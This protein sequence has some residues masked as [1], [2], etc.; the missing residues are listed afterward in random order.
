MTAHAAALRELELLLR[1]AGAGVFVVSTGQAEQRAVQRAIYGATTDAEVEERLRARLAGLSSARVVM[2]GVPSDVGAGYVR[3]AN[4]GPQAIRARMAEDDPNYASWLEARGV[5][6][7]GDVLVVPQL[8]SDEMLSEAQ[9]ERTRRAC[10]PDVP[11]ELR[12]TLP[13]SPLSKAERVLDLALSIAPNAAPV[14]LGGD[15]SCAWPAV[16]ALA[17]ARREPWGVVQID[18]HT[19]LLAERL[20]VRTCFA[21]WSYHANEL[22]GR[23]GKLVQVGIRATRHDRAHWEGTLGVRQFWADECLRDPAAALDAIA[24]HVKATGVRGV[25]FSNDIDGT[26]ERFADATGTPEPNGLEPDFVVALMRRLG[27]EVGL[28]GGDVMEVAP[29]VARTPDGARRTVGLAARYLRETLE[30]LTTR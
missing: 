11:D 4:L 12:R 18:A 16:A 15:H 26:D 5:V 8:L 22:L 3:G 19:D 7:V 9:I 14:V 21:T 30:R 28:I 29:P 27:A 13:V 25:Y 6:D 1:P 2:L 10:W 23:G 20:G 24:L 17:R